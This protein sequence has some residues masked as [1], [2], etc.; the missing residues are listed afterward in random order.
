MLAL[1]RF[2]R[3]DP[4][5]TLPTFGMPYL[6]SHP[7]VCELCAAK[8]LKAC[9]HLRRQH[10]VLRVRAFGPVGVRGALYRPG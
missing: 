7:P 10:S 9:P 3:A 4:V 2:S 6:T 1:P 8:A 5:M